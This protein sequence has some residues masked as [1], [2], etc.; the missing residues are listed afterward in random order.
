MNLP[1][2]VPVVLIAIAGAICLIPGRL[3]IMRATKARRGFTLEEFVTVFADDRHDRQVVEKVYRHYQHRGGGTRFLVNPDD[4]LEKIYGEGREDID[5]D[6][7]Q[8]LDQSGIESPSQ[9]VMRQYGKPICSV[10]DVVEYLCWLRA[11]S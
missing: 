11:D 6:V 5:D 7:R 9:N 8:L 3:A 2:V 4:S 10:R 1:L